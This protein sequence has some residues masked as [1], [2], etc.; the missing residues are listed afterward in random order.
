MI[1]IIEKDLYRPIVSNYKKR[2]DLYYEIRLY[3]RIIDIFLIGKN[4]VKNSI[5][6]EFKLKDWKKALIQ[7]NSYFLIANYV[8]IVLYYTHIKNVDIELLKKNG[9]GLISASKNNYHIIL[10]QKKNNKI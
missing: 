3:S 1:K 10:R 7:A 5:A 9:L 6:M 8:Y 4:N 2:Y